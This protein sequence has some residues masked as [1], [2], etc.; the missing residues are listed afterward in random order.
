[1]KKHHSVRSMVVYV[2]FLDNRPHVEGG[3]GVR[4]VTGFVSKAAAKRNYE[5]VRTARLVFD[6]DWQKDA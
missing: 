2:G 5:D 4:T 3:R 6:A 1:M